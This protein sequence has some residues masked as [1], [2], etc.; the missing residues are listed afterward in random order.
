MNLKKLHGLKKNLLEL[1]KLLDKGKFPKVLMLSGKK[2][3]GK[4]TLVHH[5]LSYI[6]DKDNYDLTNTTINEKNKITYNLKENLNP[7][8]VYYKCI[9]KNVKIDDIRNLRVNLQKSSINNINRFVIF[10]DVECLNENCINALLKSIEEPSETN[11]FILINNKSQKLIDTLKSRSIEIK[12][13]LSNNEKVNIIQNLISEYKIEKNLRYDDSTLTPGNYLKFNKLIS[14][15]QLDLNDLLIKN[16][17]KLLK[18]SKVKKDIDY[19]NFAIYLI[20]QHYL[21]KS[22]KEPNVTHYNEYRINVIK[23]LQESNK[24]NLNPVN[25]ITEIENY[26]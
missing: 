2:G 4:F 13:F 5:F 17:E 10:D 9:D 6:F 1:F 11:Y 26:I 16:I 24:L 25:L 15:E 8:I 22:K 19:L 7:N 21:T 3:Q 18:L 23:K 12:I 20:N 14:D